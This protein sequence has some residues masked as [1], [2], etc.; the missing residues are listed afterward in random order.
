[1]QIPLAPPE[2]TAARLERR[3]KVPRGFSLLELLIV[4]VIMG[5]LGALV[6]PKLLDKLDD[7]KAKT[8]ETQVRMLKSALDTMRLDFGRYPTADEGLQLLV[9]PPADPDAKSRWHGPYLEDAMPLDPW[10]KPYLYS[11]EGKEP[12]PIALYSFGA[13]GKP[14][15]EVIG[16]PPRN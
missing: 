13:S 14:G 6:G 12:H 2:E 15:G 8:A 5:L 7:S 16:F 11:P 3:R 9:S 4:L 1:M 10:G